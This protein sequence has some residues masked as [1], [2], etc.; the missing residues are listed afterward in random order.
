M[1]GIVGLVSREGSPDRLKKSLDQ[2]VHRGPDADGY[3]QSHFSNRLIELGHRR[4][5]ILDLTETAN[6]PMKGQKG[7]VIAFN[8]EIYNYLELRQELS[9]PW[10]TTSDTEVLLAALETWGILK[11]LEK[12]RGMFAFLWQ[13]EKTLYAARDNFGEKPLFFHASHDRIAF[14]S[15]IRALIPLIGKKTSLDP[16]AIYEFLRGGA[17]IAPRTGLREVAKL[18]PGEL[19]TVDLREPSLNPIITT[20]YRPLV[21][22][23]RKRTAEELLDILRKSVAHRCRADVPVG[24]F[25]SGGWDSSTLAALYREITPKI[26]GFTVAVDYSHKANEIPYARA[27]AE[28]LDIGLEKII[29]SEEDFESRWELISNKLDVLVSDSVLV[30]LHAISELAH[31]HNHKVVLGGEG[32]DEIFW[33]Y[34]NY[35]R[36]ALWQQRLGIFKSYLWHSLDDILSINTK[37]DA[38][39]RVL[40][41][42]EAL[43]TAAPVLT[44]MQ[45]CKC[46][47]RDFSLSAEASHREFLSHFPG[48]DVFQKVQVSE[49]RWRLPEL[50]L[51]R[52]D[53]A[54]MQNSLEVRAPFLAPEVVEFGINTIPS[55]KYDG[56]TEKSLF[57]EAVGKLL[58]EAVKRPKIGFCGSAETMIPRGFFERAKTQL[59]EE[60]PVELHGVKKFC[61]DEFD[62]L[63]PY[64]KWTLITLGKVI[65]NWGH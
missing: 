13:D 19:L 45:A 25:L 39:R 2:L 14:A 40:T 48:A 57:K 32:A 52:L 9:Y 43:L 28:H 65:R 26:T 15:E 50:L 29:I 20:W 41:G 44:H 23:P 62:L 33:G 60:L 5:S 64:A 16:D 24:V 49:L 36:A 34:R 47:G 59:L 37:T 27:V 56:K 10:K 4:L 11:T 3:H 22:K 31:S 63:T 53:W 46:L 30:P 38:I 1:C 18:G 42:D 12:I 7:S 8:G 35:T 55:Q 58:P 17:V 51:M 54:T 6:Q 61:E 21:T